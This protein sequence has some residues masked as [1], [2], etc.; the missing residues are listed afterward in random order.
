MEENPKQLRGLTADEVQMR[1]DAG[2]VNVAS[3]VK[4]K[5]VSRIFYD[6]ICTLFNF[7]NVILFVALLL[8]G[9]YKNLLF[10]GVVLFNTVIGIVQEIRSKKSVDTLTILTE[11]KL[12]VLRDGKTIQLSK[13]ELV[14]DDIIVLSRG[15]QVP[16][17]CL[18]IEG[19]CKANESL[20]TGESDLIEKNEGD[21]LLSGSFVSAGSCY[22]RVHRVGADSYAAKINN[23]AKY[24]KKNNS[25]ILK[26]FKFIINLCTAVI[27]PLGILLFVSK[28]FIQP[29]AFRTPWY[30][31]SA[32][33]SA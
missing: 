16:A 13:D 26:S 8:V 3:G 31:R 24:I 32:R 14:L 30:P 12:D 25:Q 15:N 23:E 4:T 5:S 6:N 19:A 22:C 20:L 10:I 18:V 2:K 29:R 1:I 33:W 7:I 28:F 27:F 21:E 9:S 17:D 11:S